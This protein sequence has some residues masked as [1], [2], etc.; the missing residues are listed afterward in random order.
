M[1]LEEQKNLEQQILNEMYKWKIL[2]GESNILMQQMEQNLTNQG[3][4]ISCVD[5]QQAVD[6]LISKKLI[7]EGFSRGLQ[8]CWR[9]D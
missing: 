7:K 8:R 3:V 9:M 4:K 2:K 5:F 1:S 6:S